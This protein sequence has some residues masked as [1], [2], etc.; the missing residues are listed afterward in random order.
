MQQDKYVIPESPKEPSES[1]TLASVP[2]R[3]SAFQP[4]QNRPDILSV[5]EETVTGHD[6]T[7]A[8]CTFAQPEVNQTSPLPAASNLSGL[9]NHHLPNS[10]QPLYRPSTLSV[11]EARKQTEPAAFQPAEKTYQPAEFDIVVDAH[12][13]GKSTSSSVF[14]L[15]PLTK[16]L[17]TLMHC[18]PSS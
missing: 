12:P 16:D 10:K 15:A 17:G 2:G 6:S 13:A 1:S 9:S 3:A 14:E 18:T 5:K 7:E 8:P 4:H 11:A